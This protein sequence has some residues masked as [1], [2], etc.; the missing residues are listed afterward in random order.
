M[1]MYGTHLKTSTSGTDLFQ[2]KQ[3]IYAFFGTKKV[4][5]A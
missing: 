4:E 3:E 2:D 5:L 1:L